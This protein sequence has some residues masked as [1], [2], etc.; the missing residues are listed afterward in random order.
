MRVLFVHRNNADHALAAEMYQVAAVRGWQLQPVPVRDGLQFGTA[1]RTAARLAAAIRRFGADIALLDGSEGSLMPA[2]TVLLVA[3]VPYVMLADRELSVRCRLPWIAARVF[4]SARAV[5]VSEWSHRRALVDRYGAMRMVEIDPGLPLDEHP[6]GE[7]REALE[8]LGLAPHQRML[9][10]ISPLDERT[11]LSLL[12]STYRNQPGLGLLVTGEGPLVDRLQAMAASTRPSSPVR[13]VGPASPATRLITACACWVGI[14][15]E[16]S[17]PG[18]GA[19][20]L[21]AQGRRLVT[22]A[23][24]DATPLLD[25]YPAEARAVHIVSPTESS[26]RAGLMA[27]LEAER[28]LGPLLLADVRQARRQLDAARYAHRIADVLEACA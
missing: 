6:L 20:I 17:G 26:F 28:T 11:R 19:R 23:G 25:L 16:A 8:V 12:D 13:L 2:A 5:V 22:T 4:R 10:M 18:V 15:L 14:D 9:G 21:L 24:E 7:R 3:R 1:A 27:A